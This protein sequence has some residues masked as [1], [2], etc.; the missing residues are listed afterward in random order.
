MKYIAKKTNVPS[1]PDVP[2]VLE[3][4]IFESG[5]QWMWTYERIKAEAQNGRKNG[6][7]HTT[8]KDLLVLAPQNDPF[9][10]GTAT[11]KQNAEWFADLW[12]R[13]GY[14]QGVHLRRIHYQIV[15]QDPPVQ[16]PNG[17]P[18]ENTDKCWNF[19][20]C[21]AKSARY[22]ELVD[23]AS[24][25]D[26]RAHEPI[27][28]YQPEGDSV[29]IDVEYPSL[30]FG[31]ELPDFPDLPEYSLSMN[32]D[33]PYQ[34]EIWTEKSTMNDVLLPLCKKYQ[35]NLVAGVGEMSVTQSVLL[36]QRL[37]ETQKPC[38]ILYV[39]DFDPAGLSMPV[40][41][42]RKTEFFIRNQDQDL[43]VELQPVVLTHDQCVKYRLPRTPI[44]ETERRAGKFEERWGEGATEL[45]ALESLHPGE[46]HRILK[47]HILRFHDNDLDDRV[48]E[49]KSQV[50]EILEDARDDVL[51]HHLE[52]YDS[53]RSEYQSLKDEFQNRVGDIRDRA[54]ELLSRIESDMF[55]NM[56]E[57]GREVL[58]EPKDAECYGKPLFD[59]MRSYRDQL[60]SYKQFQAGINGDS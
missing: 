10:V 2:A 5:D 12:S 48:M 7:E 36:M 52:Q 46:L 34:V 27:V 8:V 1:D 20:A 4:D 47:S 37:T 18:Y 55:D 21:A 15:S 49:R 17:K 50:W 9:Y 33:Q 53:L 57:I 28:N 13:F 31:F 26:R 35:V 45:D 59:S 42:A 29:G 58:P 41:A 38:R 54:E 30:E 60:Q 32:V 40:A 16:M 44:K 3:L 14:H 25:D 39:S 6:L 23:P 19:L 56:P 22:L 11:D 24:F 43:D 51:D